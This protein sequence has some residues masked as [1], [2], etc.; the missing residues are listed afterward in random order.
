MAVVVARWTHIRAEALCEQSVSYA[1]TFIELCM[2]RY[3]VC[4]AGFI[5]FCG[6]VTTLLCP[7]CS[8]IANP[9]APLR[10]PPAR[11]FPT[12]LENASNFRAALEPCHAAVTRF[13]PRAPPRRCPGRRRLPLPPKNHGSSCPIAFSWRPSCSH[14]R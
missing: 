3:G 7:A 6:A 11:R 8:S 12:L 14:A 4:G 9:L 13:W 2:H 10:Q 5:W 1:K